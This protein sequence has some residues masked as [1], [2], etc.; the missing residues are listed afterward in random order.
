[1]KAET[2]GTAGR[3]LLCCLGGTWRIS[4]LRPSSGIVRYPVLFALWHG[5]QLPFIFTHRNT[6][7]RV[8]IS[9]SRDGAIASAICERMGFKP[10]RGS[11]NREGVP[12]VRKIIEALLQDQ[13]CA[14][15][16]DGPK[17][18]AEVMKRGA[19]LI[20]QRAGV[21][22]IP[23]GAGAFPALRLKSW[24]R[25]LIP[26]PFAKVI[27]TEGMPV[28]PLSSPEALS[29][30][31]SQESARARLA[32][33]PVSTITISIIRSVARLLA[34]LAWLFL[35]F[36]PY[37][38]RKERRGFISIK[39][40][41]PVWLHGASLG[42]M[43]GLIPVT[44]SL[45]SAD[46]PFFVTGSTPAA[47]DYIKSENLEGSFLPIDTPGAVNRFLNRLS[48]SSLILAETEFWPVL[49]HET[50]IRGIPAGMVNARLSRKSVRGYSFI[51]PLFGNILSCFRG[52]LTRS[53]TDSARFLSLGVKSETAGD[54]K[55][56]VK[57]PDPDPAWIN[58]I[59][60]GS[61]GIIVA[62]STRNGEEETI[63]SIARIA[64]LTPVLVPRHSN[65]ISE[66]MQTAL[67]CGF[68]P[69]LWTDNPTGSTCLVVN[70][71]GILA[72]LY[73]LADIAFVGGTLAPE[74]GHNIMEP[75]AHSVPVIIGPSYHH[76]KDVVEEGSKRNI[77]RVFSTVDQGAEAVKYL[78][79]SRNT[80]DHPDDAPSAEVFSSKLAKLLRNMGITI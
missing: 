56:I 68:K 76:F 24:D 46:I 7:V 33:D 67:K 64:G 27:I 63:L 71:Q 18:P 60:K 69:D 62:G 2:A 19:A 13:S 80:K 48:P 74:G 10:I 1:V 50:V 16:P 55:A 38:E 12:A 45:R 4:R 40:N 3:I 36:R 66:V 15:T 41:H 23:C 65:R 59:K 44:E 32:T 6:G 22:F 37:T 43:K 54:G 52:I 26:L 57:P 34:P 72:S 78:L 35:L 28:S 61:C 73:G 17:G 29:A 42:E 30:A 75:L 20:P 70:I 14:I 53:E 25:F 77:C 21:P 79:D 58:R 8:L 31:I 49:L 47:R 39:N 51:K 5:A 11:S 9:Q